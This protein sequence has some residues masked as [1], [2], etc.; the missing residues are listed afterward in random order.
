MGRRL[1][2]PVLIVLLA[3]IALGSAS[4]LRAEDQDQDPLATA[5]RHLQAGRLF[6]AEKAARTAIER[7]PDSA[8]A[9]L[10]LGT[11][12]VRRTH[13]ED[14]ESELSRAAEIDPDLPGVDRELGLVRFELDDFEGAR[15]SLERAVEIAPED[16]D[17]WLRLGLCLLALEQ[18]EPAAEAFEVAARDPDLTSIANYNLGVARRAMGDVDEARAAFEEALRGGLPTSVAERAQRHLAGFPKPTRP[19]TLSAAAGALYE[20]SVAQ[21]AND[22]IDRKPDGAGQIEVGGSYEL[23]IDFVGSSVGYDFY[24]KLY[25]DTETFDLQSHTFNARMGKKLGPVS[26]SLG[27]VYSLNL[28]GDSQDRFLDFHEIRATGGMSLTDWWYA[29]FSPGFRAKRFDRSEDDQRDANTAVVGL[30]QL[31]PLGDW[32]RYVLLGV[33]Y[34]YENAKPRY[35][36]NGLRA[37]LSFHL[38][39]E[40]FSRELPIDIRYVFQLRDYRNDVSS[41]GSGARQDRGHFARFRLGIPLAGPFRL[42]TEYEFERVDSQFDSADRTVHQVGMLL[43]FE[44]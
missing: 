23:P 11:I 15:V 41:V 43:Q 12:L 42:Q 8:Q 13:F 33:T 5:R 21:P 7:E 6:P 37:Q 2:H 34:E 24:Q 22:Q 19:F 10:V 17:L 38:P 31:F 14:A 1:S 26:T 39:V 9:H 32:S 3:F 28:L 20:S 29:S 27:Y 36:H 18:P 40:V 25:F 16:F 44:Y 35:D 4:A 30:L